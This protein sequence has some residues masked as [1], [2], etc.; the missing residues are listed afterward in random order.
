MEVEADALML[1]V[2]G[3]EQAEPHRWP[4]AGVHF[5]A[6]G[7]YGEPVR[8]EK[9]DSNER[10]VVDSPDFLDALQQHGI[11][12]PH[13]ALDLHS[14]QAVLLCSLAI[15]AIAGF[16]YLRGVSWASEYA[17]Q[18]LPPAFE[19]RLGRAIVNLLAPEDTRCTDPKEVARLEPV[20]QRLQAAVG[21]K[22]KFTVYYVDQKV[23]NAFAAPGGYVVV[24][25]GLIEQAGSPEEL[26]GVLAHE[27]QHVLL[28]HSARA[29]A[30]E[31]SGQALLALM[32]MDSSGTPAAL[33][34][35]A[36][37]TNLSYQRG[38]EAA[39][40]ANGTDMLVRAR[41]EPNG[42]ITFFG[43]L[44]R[45]AP[46]SGSSF[47]SSH[48][49]TKDRVEALKARVQS[50]PDNWEPIMTPEEWQRA[51]NICASR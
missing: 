40:D 12:K 21:T 42:L 39:A 1:T 41:I 47:L 17:V 34:Y 49:A 33:Q 35:G 22:Q 28:R 20:F 7:S 45:L 50:L 38:D 32:A 19:D 44:E 10:L 4:Y 37:L 13:L 43:R 3:F 16:M 27:M 18:Y 46:D 29:L 31:F 8:I 26:A 2:Q 6:D 30:R 48:P 25:R 23:V 51:R 36:Q 14:W 11:A 24:F 9:N 15:V 5:A